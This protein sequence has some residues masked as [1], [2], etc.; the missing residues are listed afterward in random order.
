MSTTVALPRALGKKLIEGVK[1]AVESAWLGSGGCWSHEDETSV[2]VWRLEEVEA[3]EYVDRRHDG[4]AIGSK[5][6]VPRFLACRRKGEV[7][8]YAHSHPGGRAEFSSADDRVEREMFEAL[9]SISGG[10]DVPLVAIVV[11]RGGAIAA[12]IWMPGANEPVDASRIRIA[13]RELDI[14]V[15]GV[16]AV[17]SPFD[18]QVRAFGTDGQDLLHQLRVGLVGVGGTG[19]AVF[20]LLVRLGITPTVVIDPDDLSDTSVTRGFGSSL[21]QVGMA[22][23]HVARDL[24]D[25][26][27]F[28]PVGVS[29][30]GSVC[31]EDVARRL[32]HC[33][34]VFACTDDHAGRLVLNRLAYRCVVPVVDLG[35]LIS[36]SAGKLQSVDGRVTWVAPG[37]ACLLCRDRV[38][39]GVAAAERMDPLVR[40]ARAAEGYAPALGQADASVI[41]YTAG[42]ASIAVAEMLHRVLAVN[43]SKASEILWSPVAHRLSSNDRPPR[44]GCFCQESPAG[45][46]E[47]FLGITWAA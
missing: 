21:D 36:S 19:S 38:D 27:G 43:D 22:K 32:A 12:R 47:N 45:S 9:G 35:V 18:R 20:E 16:A 31:D 11:A 4:L 44:S 14:R 34:V 2:A 30:S 8:V 28:R 24:A 23:V 39:A 6:W 40:E 3:H 25:R 7:V 29:L 13:G 10:S 5:A 33:D 17:A 42:I 41:T 46:D 15:G 1:V 37:S 26:I